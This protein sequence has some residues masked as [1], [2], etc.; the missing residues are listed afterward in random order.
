[1]LGEQIE[2]YETVRRAHM[3]FRLNGWNSKEGK[4]A[5]EKAE[6]LIK[7]IY[8]EQCVRKGDLK[9]RDKVLERIKDAFYH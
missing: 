4:E 1:M 9:I 5:L 7:R 6:D 8:E 3:I 2:K